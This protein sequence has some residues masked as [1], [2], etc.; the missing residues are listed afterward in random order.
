MPVLQK[1][2]TCEASDDEEVPRTGTLLRHGQERAGM[3]GWSLNK[4]HFS[5]TSASSC[6]TRP[7]RLLEMQGIYVKTGLEDLTGNHLR[8]LAIDL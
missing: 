4:P 2:I 1:L 5:S 8:R 7:Q 6:A 3:P